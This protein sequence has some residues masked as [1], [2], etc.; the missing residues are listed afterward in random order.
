MAN[1]EEIHNPLALSELILAHGVDMMTCTPSYLINII[2]MPEMREALSQIRVFN[3]GA[4]AFPGVLYD[5]IMALGTDAKVFN[6]YGPTETT[7]GCAFEPV[8]GESVTIGKPMANIQMMMLDKYRN[9]LPAGV[10]GEML[11]IGNGVGRGY[12]GKPEMTADKFIAFEGKKAY[13]SGGSRAVEPPRE[14]RVYGAYGQSGQ[15]ARTAC[16][17]R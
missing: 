1:E 11:I 14:D 3:V 9:L 6:G 10:P 17:A 16:R 12:V 15:T 7:I 8:T 4:E 5:K 13:R 2:D